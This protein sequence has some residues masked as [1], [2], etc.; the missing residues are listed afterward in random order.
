[1]K[2]LFLGLFMFLLCFSVSADDTLTNTLSIDEDKA[3]V[4]QKVYVTLENV[5]EG[6]KVTVY[7]ESEG[8]DTL[9]VEVNDLFVNP[10][11]VVPQEAKV[12]T[13]Y[14]INKFDITD[15]YLGDINLDGKINDEDVE[16]I[17]KHLINES[18]LTGDELRRADVDKN[19]TIDSMDIVWIKRYL[20]DTS[21]IKNSPFTESYSNTSTN[22]K[23]T[24]TEGGYYNITFGIEGD[25]T[26][27]KVCPTCTD[28]EDVVLPTPTKEGYSFSGWFADSNFTIPINNIKDD[29]SKIITSNSSSTSRNITLYSKWEKVS[30]VEVENTGKNINL[31][32]IIAAIFSIII[33]VAVININSKRRINNRI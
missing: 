7:L 14:T 17:K 5:K 19:S 27:I 15:T 12:G 32:L 4:E 25:I 30:N 31:A 2:K 21:I 1:M 26:T 8:N 18:T 33:G 11:F 16:M 3:Y 24:I 10:Y 6:D 13:T 29:W 22:N 9:E 23:L 28:Y 20:V